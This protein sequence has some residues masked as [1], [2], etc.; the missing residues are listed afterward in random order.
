M[1][2]DMGKIGWVDITVNTLE[3]LTLPEKALIAWSGTRG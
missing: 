3:S 1:L 2:G